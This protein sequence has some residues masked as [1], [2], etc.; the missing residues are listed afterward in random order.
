MDYA[1]VSVRARGRVLPKPRKTSYFTREDESW[2]ATPSSELA[3]EKENSLRCRTSILGE[4]PRTIAHQPATDT[5]LVSP[6]ST[7]EWNEWMEL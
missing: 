7:I 1:L 2:L 5:V 4:I 3:P 6:S